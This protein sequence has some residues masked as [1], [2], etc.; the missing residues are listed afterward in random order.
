M[1]QGSTVIVG[2][3][4]GGVQTAAGLR[5]GGYEGKIVLL[6]DELEL[7]YHRPPLSKSPQSSGVPPDLLRPESFFQDQQIDLIRGRKVVS[8]DTANRTVA[9]IDGEQLAFDHLVLA[10]GARPRT[11]RQVSSDLGG[12]FAIRTVAQARALWSSPVEGASI[13]VVGA[14]FVGLEYAAAARMRGANVVVVESSSRVLGRAVSEATSERVER[15]HR[16][17]GVEIFFGDGVDSVR[18]S[19]G[20]VQSLQLASGRRLLAGHVL[21]AV[22]AAPCEELAAEAGLDVADGIIVDNNMQTAVAGIYAVGDCARWLDVSGQSRRLESVQNASDQGACVAKAILGKPEPFEPVPW[23]WSNQAVLRLQIAGLSDPRDEV[24]TIPNDAAGE[25]TVI[26]HNDARLAS[27]ETLNRPG[28]HLAARRL[29]G[30]PVDI[31][32]L[33]AGNVTL[34]DL[35]RN[36]RPQR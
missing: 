6:G 14:G 34:R 26:R 30:K 16:S 18:S 8:I 1:N 21:V 15:F 36:A 31:T 2:A 28:D 11:I 10:T 20:Q 32:A 4:L 35:A 25:L 17:I 19:G 29:I 33:E 5:Q 24:I 12:V 13:V 27:V 22:G 23:F 3:G 7:P 9:L